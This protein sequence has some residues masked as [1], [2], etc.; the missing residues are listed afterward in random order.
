MNNFNVHF[1]PIQTKN[2]WLDGLIFNWNIEISMK[3][4]ISTKCS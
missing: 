4:N 1:E 2:S 3:I